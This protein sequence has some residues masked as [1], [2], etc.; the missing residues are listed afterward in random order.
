MP[1]RADRETI[2]FLGVAFLIVAF[3]GSLAFAARPLSANAEPRIFSVRPGDGFRAIA[4]N[5]EHAH[6]IRSSA[7]FAVL[8]IVRGDARSLK[9]G[10]YEFSPS[11]SMGEILFSLKN[12]SHRD[13]LIVVPEGASAFEIDALLA[14]AHVLSAGEFLGVVNAG[15][16]EGKMFPDTYRFFLRSMPDAVAETFLRN[17]EAKAAPI[18]ADDPKRARE[19]LI[20][21]S[22]L[23]RE[24][25]GDEDRAL[26]SGILK[27]RLASGMPLQADASICYI[28]RARSG[29]RP[30][31]NCYPLTPLDFK[32]DSP[33]NTY[34][35]KGLP[36]EPIGNPGASA[37]YAAVHPRSSPFWFYLSDP[38]TK[39][40]VFSKTFE[41]HSAQRSEY[42]INR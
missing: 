34:L 25:P 5:L 7:A 12:G 15:K 38:V 32:V 11:M 6:L 27:K 16:F 36:P 18:L 33:Y 39:K 21:A 3:A 9:T 31:E 17:F 8:A 26:V 42:L 19:N 23:E 29:F 30:G 28:K 40:T 22:L 20:I 13:A 24:V 2:W 4:D 10:D 35:Y 14:R 41:E 1:L 37:L